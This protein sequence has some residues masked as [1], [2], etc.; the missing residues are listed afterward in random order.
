M[1]DQQMNDPRE[2]ITET[3]EDLKMEEV[4]M[5]DEQYEAA[6]DR[7]FSRCEGNYL[8]EPDDGEWEPEDDEEDED[9]DYTDSGWDD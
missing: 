7:E 9:E 6:M 8:T 2:I 3:Y 5:F 4:M 1:E